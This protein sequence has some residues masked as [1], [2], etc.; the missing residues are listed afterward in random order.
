[1][2]DLELQASLE[3]RSRFLAA[4]L[5]GWVALHLFALIMMVLPPL[6][7]WDQ[8]LIIGVSLTLSL[9]IYL[10]NRQGYV[11]LAALLFCLVTNAILILAFVVSLAF[12]NTPVV[13]AMLG[14]LLSLGILFSGMLIRP[15]AI[16]WFTGLNI[17]AV[18][19]P[20]LRTSETVAEGIGEGFPVIAFLLLIALISW[21]Y[22]QTLNQALDSLT[23]ARQE[24]ENARILQR[25]IDIAHNLQ[26]QLYPPPPQYGQRICFAARCEPAHET[27]GDF[28]DFLRLDDDH[29]G[30][31][32]ADVSGKSI[33]AAMVMAM[34]RSI[35][36][37]G[38]RL[39]LS[40]AEV[41]EQTN[42]TAIR[43]VSIDQMITVFYGILNTKT[44]E[45]VYANA[46]HPYPILKR[47]GSVVSLDVPGFPIRTFPEANYK[48]HALQLEPGDQLIWISDG[49]VEAHNP[50]N[51][52]FG[53]EQL[54]EII[55]RTDH[56][57]PEGM[58]DYIWRA[59]HNHRGEAVQTDDIT[60]V[61]ANF[62]PGS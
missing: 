59:V 44:L 62:G 37:H 19:I 18:S 8:F 60:L 48:D 6:A 55:H 30:I 31:V 33:S 36:R 23:A 3:R 54:E 32:V 11:R 52:L 46:G 35:I 1:M 58:L 22:Q 49:I 2:G 20:F 26:Q 57:S 38:A 21:L 61:V 16:F 13:S 43:D 24:A 47:N 29:L 14:S 17:L 51:Q 15:R 25:E 45:L 10:L 28:Y 40:P 53:F 50:Q 42:K 9:G 4:L 5:K 12:E 27:G 7:H 39:T 34:T 56:H 41:L